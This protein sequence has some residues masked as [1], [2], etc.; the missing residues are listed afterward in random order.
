MYVLHTI[1]S[2]NVSCLPGTRRGRWSS[3]LGRRMIS[4]CPS[5]KVPWT[6]PPTPMDLSAKSAPEPRRRASRAAPEPR[7]RASP[8]RARSRA[9]ASGI[10][11]LCICRKF[12]PRRRAN[13]RRARTMA[14]GRWSVCLDIPRKFE[15][16]RRANRRRARRGTTK[17]RVVSQALQQ[18]VP[19]DRHL[20]L[21][22][23]LGAALRWV[24]R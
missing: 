20:R 5:A 13:R 16:R 6:S 14:M 4:Q 7:R 24:R 8:G 15:P 17:T 23:P 18:H 1:V 21:P 19:E 10:A 3:Y 22:C 9:R 11:H 2:M 12:E